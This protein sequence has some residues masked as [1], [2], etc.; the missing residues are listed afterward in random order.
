M[1]DKFRYW[2]LENATEITWFLIGVLTLSGLQ[3]LA[4]GNYFG[5]IFNFALVGLNYAI[6]RK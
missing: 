5:A 1:L 2:Y 3:D 6:S 4:I